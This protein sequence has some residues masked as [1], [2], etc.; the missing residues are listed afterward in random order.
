MISP[1]P[2]LPQSDLSDNNGAAASATEAG[3][4]KFFCEICKVGATSQQQLDMHL[5]G[6]AH[7]AR[8]SGTPLA[9][10]KLKQTQPQTP[11]ES[12]TPQPTSAPTPTLQV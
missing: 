2:P 3:R 4:S 1:Y 12:E 8:E 6:K 11:T 9:P 10:R 5:N 7:K